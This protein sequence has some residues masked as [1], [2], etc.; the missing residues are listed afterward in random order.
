MC[1]V[2]Q[3]RGLKIPFPYYFLIYTAGLIGRGGQIGQNVLPMLSQVVH[4]GVQK[5][6]LPDTMGS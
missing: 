1:L 4:I 5:A 2:I 3:E 6:R